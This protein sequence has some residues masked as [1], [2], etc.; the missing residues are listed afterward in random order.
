MWQIVAAQENC[1]G[2]KLATGLGSL[3]GDIPISNCA[4]DLPL[5]PD[6]ASGQNEFLGGLPELPGLFPEFPGFEF[7]PGLPELESG[8][9]LPG[10]PN[11]DCGCSLRCLVCLNYQICQ[12][13]TIILVSTD[14]GHTR[15]RRKVAVIWPNRLVGRPKRA[16]ANKSSAV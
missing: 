14:L 4:P 16:D 13:F 7:A 8:L 15:R 10:L 1:P 2:V 9:G 11:G 3:L 6:L 5:L 12:I